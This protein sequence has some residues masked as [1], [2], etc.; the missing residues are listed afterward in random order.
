VVTVSLDPVRVESQLAAGTL[1][2]PFCD[3]RLA[4]WAWARERS[5]GR[6]A[7]RERVRP[8]RSRC[9]SC[10]AT[11]VL[12]P[13]TMLVRRGDWAATIGRALELKAAG[14]GQRPIAAA[15]GASRWTVRGWLSRF[16]VVADAVRAHLTRWALWL[17][18][19]LVRFDPTGTPLGDA[20]AAVAAAGAAAAE[21]L[22]IGCRWQFAS[23]ATGGRLLANTTSPFPSAWMG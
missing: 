2:C 12:L 6:E 20:V 10:R 4:P 21:R 14:L 13:A 22:G 1:T 8:R 16:A 3:G 9:R 23:A 11:H 15:V 17:D 7:G 19:G 5:V 18:P